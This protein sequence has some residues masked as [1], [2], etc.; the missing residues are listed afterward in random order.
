VPIRRW[1]WRPAGLFVCLLAIVCA[2]GGSAPGSTSS[3]QSKVRALSHRLHRLHPRHRTCRCRC[4]NSNV[5]QTG[6]KHNGVEPCMFTQ[7]TPSVGPRLQ[8]LIHSRCIS[9]CVSM[10]H[11][12]HP[13]AFTSSRG[14]CVIPRHLRHLAAFASS[15][16]VCVIPQHRRHLLIYAIVPPQRVSAHG[17]LLLASQTVC[18]R[19]FCSTPAKTILQRKRP[20]T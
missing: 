6:H 9:N 12:R 4:H 1:F 2:R 10:L 11:L 14:V 8:C 19:S 18:Q 13:T 7:A 3:R 5:W 16:G 20:L 15:R 17:L